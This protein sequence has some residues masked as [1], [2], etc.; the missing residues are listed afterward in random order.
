M[1]YLFLNSASEFT[2][3][4]YYCNS[5]CDSVCESHCG[6]VAADSLSEEQRAAA[7]RKHKLLGC[8]PFFNVPGKLCSAPRLEEF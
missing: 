2:S 6:T 4:C 8:I 5:R 1:E 7:W 3:H